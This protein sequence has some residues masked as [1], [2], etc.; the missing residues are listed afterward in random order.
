M[1]ICLSSITQ[2]IEAKTISWKTVIEQLHTDFTKLEEYSLAK[3]E[4]ED[5]E[6]NATKPKQFQPGGRAKSSAKDPKNRTCIQII[7][8]GK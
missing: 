2:P 8:P 1:S 4:E 7:S 3:R 5:S 6:H